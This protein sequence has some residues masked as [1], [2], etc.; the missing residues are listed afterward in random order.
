MNITKRTR[1]IKMLM[2]TVNLFKMPIDI[3]IQTVHCAV[4][5]SEVQT[6]QTQTKEAAAQTLCSHHSCCLLIEAK[7]AVE[8]TNKS[9]NTELLKDNDEATKLYT[10]LPSW[11]YFTI[12]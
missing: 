5:D 10:G 4:A 12:W 3:G 2:K 1:G 11:R 6:E 9:L 7:V 8:S